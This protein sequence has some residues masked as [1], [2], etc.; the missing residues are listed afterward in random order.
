MSRLVATFDALN[1]TALL[2]I[3]VIIIIIGLLLAFLGKGALRRF[4]GLIGSV[5]GGSVGYIIGGSLSSGSPWLAIALGFIGAILGSTLLTYATN[6][7]LAFFVGFIAA[8]ATYLALGGTPVGDTR[9]T[10]DPVMIALL[11]MVI[12]FSIVYYFIDEL[13][14]FLTALI[15]AALVGAGTFLITQSQLYGGVVL[16]V[17]FLLGLT[18][19][20]AF[21]K[22]KERRPR[23]VAAE[24]Y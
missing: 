14:A 18:V 6:V 7:A 24:P 5:I 11:V 1:S 16:G 9:A 3:G 23:P 8:G 4:M 13:M 2:I 19:Q 10:E 15:G 20:M 22:R 17:V 21:A 12:V